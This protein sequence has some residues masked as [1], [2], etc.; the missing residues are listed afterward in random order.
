[1]CRCAA[2]RRAVDIDLPMLHVRDTQKVARLRDIFRD[3]GSLS[4]E[5]SLTHPIVAVYPPRWEPR[6]SAGRRSRSR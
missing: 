2:L 3:S 1:M 5:M 6:P 4:T